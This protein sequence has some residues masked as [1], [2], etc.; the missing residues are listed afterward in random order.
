MA[1]RHE[2][3]RRQLEDA[4]LRGPGHLEPRV[5]EAIAEGRD[6]PEPLRALLEKVRHHAY[7]VTD[8]DFAPLRARYNDDELFET[9]VAGTLGAALVRV[10]AGLEAIDE[11]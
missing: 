5:R 2:N 9:V 3:A 6:V 10:R 1:D 7:R 11:A 8:A 4:V